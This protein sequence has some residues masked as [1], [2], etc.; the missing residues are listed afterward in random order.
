M[1]A[2]APTRMNPDKI[3]GL[4]LVEEEP[5]I[6]PDQILEGAHKPRGAPLFR[7]DELVI[8]VYEDEPGTFALTQPFPYDEFVMVVS[9]KL[10]LTD[11]AG[12]VQEFVAGESVVVP[13][14]F[15]GIWK[16]EGNYRELIAIERTAYDNANGLEAQ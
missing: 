3:A 4:G 11:A 9:G 8:E 5:F 14:G 7:G 6:S 16:M 2:P 1:N 12:R 15:T 10:I 13:K